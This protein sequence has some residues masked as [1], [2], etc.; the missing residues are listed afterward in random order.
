MMSAAQLAPLNG[1]L[2]RQH[3]IDPETCIRC[4]TCETRCPTEAITHNADN[5]VVDPAR[6]TFCMACNRPCPTGAID[7]WFFVDHPYTREEQFR[8]RELPAQV[9]LPIPRGAE[10]APDA[11]DDEALALLEAAHQG[12][13]GRARAPASASKPQINAFNRLAPAQALVTGTLRVTAENASSDVRHIILDFGAVPFPYLEGQSIG[14]IPPGKG[15]EGRPHA[16]RLYS[17][18]SARDGERPNTNNLALTVKRTPLSRA[19][20]GTAQGIASNWLCDLRQGDRIE[21]TGPYGATFLL[22]DDPEADL[23]MICTG[24]GVSPF[25]GFTHRRRRVA[26]NA[27]GKLRL[28]FGARSPEELPY[29][30]PLQKYQR[31]QLDCDLVYSRVPGTPKEYVQ[32]RLR[33]RATDIADLLQRETAHLYICGLSGLEQGVEE[34]LTDIGRAHGLDWQALRAAMRAAG[35]FHVETY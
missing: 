4:N 3:L 28:L 30:G 19:A 9:A 10:G 2:R 26:P 6:C 35:R 11:L 15:A 23:L 34:A 25:R 14:V 17:V 13:R 16:M 20:D 5:Y 12:M 7:N 29:F 32:D 18:A 33:A 22:P 8:W 27:R 31:T 24:T 21:V 1:T